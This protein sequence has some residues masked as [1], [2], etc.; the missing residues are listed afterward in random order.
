MVQHYYRNVHAIV[1]VYDVTNKS[2]F[3]SLKHW[4]DECDKH[5]FTD[6]PR[7]LVGN[8]CDEH[9]AVNTNLA[10]RFAD[11]HDMPLFETS[12]RLDSHCDNVE[13]IFLTLAHKLK[14][15]K[16]L[17][18]KAYILQAPRRLSGSVGSIDGSQ[19]GCACW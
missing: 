16:P 19:S 9:M 3:D 10:Q 12:A 18:P 15:Q 4:L 17:I 8:K 14:S 6:I 5:C 13:A 7:I 11:Q 2:S 1:I